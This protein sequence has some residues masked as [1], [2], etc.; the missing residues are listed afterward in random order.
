MTTRI[1]NIY[2]GTF[3]Y[4]IKM[5]QRV[6]LVPPTQEQIQENLERI[7]Q[8]LPLSISLRKLSGVFK[9]AF[10]KRFGEYRRLDEDELKHHREISK[11]KSLNKKRHKKWRQEQKEYE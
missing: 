9:E 6:A 3:L 11:I 10:V 5:K 1:R 7:E 4:N 2:K 8:G